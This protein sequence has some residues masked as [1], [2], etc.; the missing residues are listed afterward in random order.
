M[1]KIIEFS[2][3]WNNKLNCTAFTSLRLFNPGKYM[4]GLEYTVI[5]KGIVKGKAVL[6]SSKILYLNQINRYIALLDTGYEEEECKKLLEEM[7][8]NKM[9]NWNTQ[10]LSLLLFRYIKEQPKTLFDE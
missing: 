6:M 5:L 1:E 4:P 3:N 10:R 8:K 7:Y 2:N 9:L